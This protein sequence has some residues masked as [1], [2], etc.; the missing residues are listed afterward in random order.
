MSGQTTPPL[1]AE[2]VR[3]FNEGRYFEAHEVLEEAWL[4]EATEV[5]ELYKGLLQVG[6]GLL[7]ARRGN[8]RGALR[9]L[10]RGMSG[11]APFSPRTLG[12]DVHALM[13][14]AAHTRGALAAPGG[15]AAFDWTS[16]PKAHLE[17]G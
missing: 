12:L 17:A 10:D 8:R 1:L 9:L 14:D 15:V 3:L 16:A 5:R 13:R 2:G 11:L 4:A 7:H 6:V